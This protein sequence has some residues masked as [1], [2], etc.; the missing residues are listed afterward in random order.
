[1]KIVI[2]TFNG[3]NEIGSFVAAYM[4]NRIRRPGVEG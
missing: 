2:L 3:F 1:M 4:I